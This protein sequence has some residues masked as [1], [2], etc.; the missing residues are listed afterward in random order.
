VSTHSIL[1]PGLKMDLAVLL[2]T[3]ICLWLAV[4]IAPLPAWLDVL[5]LFAGSAAGALW[6]IWRT[7][8]TL[9]RVRTELDA[10]G[11]GAQNTVARKHP[12]AP[13]E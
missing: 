8:R 4:A 2:L 5:I 1:L 10:H 11:S 3:L 6:L 12:R 7:R 13:G 9:G